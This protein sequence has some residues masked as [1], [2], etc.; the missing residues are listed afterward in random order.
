MGE[1][2]IEVRSWRTEHRG[3]LLICASM[4]PAFYKKDMEEMEEEWGCVFLYGHALCAV[5]LQE[6]RPMQPGDEEFA[7]IA[8]HEPDAYSWILEDI[9][10]IVPFAQ[11][12]R[13]GLFEVPDELI[14]LPPFTL[15]ES[16]VVK[17][18]ICDSKLGIDQSGWQGRV[19]SIIPTDE[20]C[21][22][23]GVL[24]DS[25][26]LKALPISIIRRCVEQGW[27]WAEMLFDPECIELATPRDSW[28]DVLT[29]MEDIR[30]SNPAMF[31]EQDHQRH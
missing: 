28:E 4:R 9:R 6:V 3:D 16:V 17:P 11:K 10:P 5:R 15:L 29:A 23:I 1:K 7:Q 13:Q 31:P 25:I 12:G 20:G 14:Q 19:T 27:D 22:V 26:A 2:S 21:F 18:G 24:L 30:K 8:E